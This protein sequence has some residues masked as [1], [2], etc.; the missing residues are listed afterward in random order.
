LGIQ[1]A[2]PLLTALIGALRLPARIR[3]VGNIIVKA[4][5]SPV[6]KLKDSAIAHA[7]S[8]TIQTFFFDL[9]VQASVFNGTLVLSGT[10]STV[11]R[12]NQI[13]IPAAQQK[14]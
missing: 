4:R 9:P 8:R 1:I 14:E 13:E 2:F 12:R 3:G 10:L 7:V 5:V 11:E 6:S